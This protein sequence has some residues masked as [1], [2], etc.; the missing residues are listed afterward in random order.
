MFEATK[1][2]AALIMRNFARVEYKA[3]N[4]GK[5]YPLKAKYPLCMPTTNPYTFYL[6][7]GGQGT[8]V[9]F[10]VAKVEDNKLF[11]QSP[12]DSSWRMLCE[13]KLVGTILPADI[14]YILPL[15]P[16]EPFDEWYKKT[17]DFGGTREEYDKLKATIDNKQAK[18]LE[19]QSKLEAK[20]AER[21]ESLGTNCKECPRREGV[22]VSPEYYSEGAARVV[23][24]GEAPGITER[25]QGKP[26][27][28]K[29]GQILRSVLSQLEITEVHFTNACLCNAEG[30]PTSLE[31]ECCQERLIKE[32]KEIDPEIV[33]LTG[34]VAA[35]ALLG[36]ERI[37]DIQGLLLRW[38]DVRDDYEVPIIPCFHPA[39][40]LRRPDL[41]KDFVDALDKAKR[42]L[43]G[44]DLLDLQP[45]AFP[46][47]RVGNNNVKSNAYLTTIR[48]APSKVSLDIE[49]SGYNPY[50]DKL[51]SVGLATKVG[52]TIHR[53][54]FS[55]E[56]VNKGALQEITANKKMVYYNGQF[57]V[58]F[59]K[60]ASIESPIS[61]D[62]ILKAYLVDSRP[63][64][65]GLKDGCRK[66][67]NAPD[68][69]EDLRQYLPTK[70]TSFEEVPM[71]VLLEY[72]SLDAAYTL[73][74]DDVLLTYMDDD[75]KWVYD[76]IL[77]PATN[78]FVEC[79]RVGIE[80]DVNKIE[81]LKVRYLARLQDLQ[82]QL[83]EAAGAATFNPRSVRDCRYLLYEVLK[84]A[85]VNNTYTT[86]RAMLEAYEGN[87]VIQLLKEFREKQKLLGTYL[88]GLLDDLVAHYVDGRR[89]FRVHPNLKLFGTTTGRISSNTPNMLGLPKEKGGIRQMFI[90][91]E[92][93]LLAMTDFRRMEMVVA[94]ILSGDKNMQ[95]A[96]GEGRDFH[97]EARERLFG[98]KD[99][100][101]HQEA[102]D[103]K[104][105]VFGPLYGR[106]IPSMAR[107]LKC[108][109]QEAKEY[110]NRLFAPFHVFLD[111]SDA[112][113][114]SAVETGESRSFFGRKRRWGLITDDN[115]KDVEHE[116]KNHP[117][118]ST[119]SDINLLTMLKVYHTI[120]HDLVMPLLPIHDAFLMS[121]DE[122]R[123]EEL[124][125]EVEHIV[126]TYPSQLLHTDMKFQ[127]ETTVGKEW[128]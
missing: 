79:S 101:T 127:V 121:V 99:S 12:T 111:W 24:V 98:K 22:F 39:A 20:W 103:A 38:T 73:A 112:Q 60:S 23:V 72:N 82:A 128:V 118:S 126:T 69:E 43:A 105:M 76:N 107:Q 66:Y 83:A 58:Q 89:T 80:A 110:F 114:A 45:E 10:F 71:E 63:G 27:V 120:D 48:A 102:L 47:N 115:I 95:A 29:S 4:D 65:L 123:H 1:L 51:L 13:V 91:D 6:D 11:R 16:L 26:F 119:A 52:D 77:I 32:I 3:T 100:Y 33:I 87:E 81:Q 67:L 92:G 97:G 62:A 42:F 117:V 64:A 37:T 74:L 50:T 124:I 57:D 56:Q 14:T 15:E 59:L 122:E 2:T 46:R 53:Y 86:G 31:V 55:W 25:I 19:K 78:M 94:S 34:A 8:E 75:D 21:S 7:T 30:T 109:Y 54:S 17:K 49:T 104:T 84:L 40:L 88:E 41:F 18:E 106:G 36:Q 9:D 116:A 96:L 28:G 5:Y 35:H 61:E 85:P 90:A 113:A 68:W 108:N 44:Q 125:R 93:K 70:L